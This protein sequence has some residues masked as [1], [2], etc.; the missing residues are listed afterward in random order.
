MPVEAHHAVGR[1]QHQVEVVGD[2]QDAAAAPLAKLSDQSVH[3]Q[4]AGKIDLLDRLVEHQKVGVAQ[5]GAGE[6]D[7]PVLAAGEAAELALH[8]RRRP[9]LVESR[10]NIGAG[11]APRHREK[12]PHRE[13]Q[14]FLRRDALGDI[15]HHQ[16]GRVADGARVRLDEA[17]QGAYGGGLAGAVRPDQAH[18]LAPADLDRDPVQHRAAA[19][20]HDEAL[21]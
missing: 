5:Q 8:H 4:L 12:A 19:I 18:H 21:A 1:A 20:A 3:G 6:Q 14:Q 17:E 15:A 2:D 7:T 10:S 13:R 11:P 16:A 9:Y